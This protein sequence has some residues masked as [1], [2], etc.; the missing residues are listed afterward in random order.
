MKAVEDSKPFA[1]K[2]WG[3]QTPIQQYTLE[4]GQIMGLWGNLDK[5]GVFWYL[6][7]RNPVVTD[8]YILV[9]LVS[10]ISLLNLYRCIYLYK[11]KFMYFDYSLMLGKTYKRGLK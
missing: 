10:N 2:Q 9:F 4:F 8:Y 5:F 7:Q 11:Y 3:R 1:S 6:Q